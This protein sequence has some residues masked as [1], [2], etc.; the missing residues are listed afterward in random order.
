MASPTPTKRIAREEE[1]ASNQSRPKRP[2]MRFARNNHSRRHQK[3]HETPP[4]KSIRGEGKGHGNNETLCD[5]R[6]GNYF[7]LIPERL[8]KNRGDT[9][10]RRNPKSAPSGQVTSNPSYAEQCA[11]R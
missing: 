11:D 2:S 6:V 7:V 8:R 5:E 9:G 3:P 10:N 4:A 1:C